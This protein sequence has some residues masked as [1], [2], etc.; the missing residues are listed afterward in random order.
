MNIY[1]PNPGTPRKPSRSAGARTGA[2]SPRKSSRQP[3]NTLEA[4]GVRAAVRSELPMKIALG[5]AVAGCVCAIY[6]TLRRSGELTTVGWMPPAVGRWCDR[7]GRF[8]NMPA[9]F[10]LACPFLV[11]VRTP[12]ARV[13][14]MIWLGL[15]GAAL[16][17]AQYFV[18]TR[19]VEW[20][21]IA[22]SWVGLAIAWAVF[23]GVEYIRRRQR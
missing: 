8:R 10:L 15:F 11:F 18:P 23:E 6:L 20:Q 19:Y 17:L 2:G 21:D 12:A 1:F 22:W 5:A 16:E 4:A 7:Y 13:R 14:L 3:G 9:Y